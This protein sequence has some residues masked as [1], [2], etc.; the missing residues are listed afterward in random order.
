MTWK[1]RPIPHVDV[2]E[3]LTLG[4]IIANGFLYLLVLMVVLAVLSL[5]MTILANFIEGCRKGWEKPKAPRRST[6]GEG[7]SS[8]AQ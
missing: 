1:W 4:E 5:A 8:G 7:G 2:I 6:A 3:G